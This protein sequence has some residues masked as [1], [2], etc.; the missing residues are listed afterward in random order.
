MQVRLSAPELSYSPGDVALV[1]P[2][3]LPDMVDSFFDLFPDLRPDRLF[4]LVP[5]SPN[6]LPPPLSLLPRPCTVRQAVTTYLD[7]QAVPS[8]YFFELLSHFSSDELE[9]EKCL[10]FNTG[11]GQQDLYEYCNRP[12]RHLLEVLHDFRHS[13]PNIPFDY[14]FDLVPAIK[15]RSFSIASSPARHGG[16][17]ELLVAVV[18]Y[19]SAID[20]TFRLLCSC[21]LHWYL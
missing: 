7:I 3:N 6:T 10:E 1:Q 11:E 17:V 15:P 19:R 4:H 14:L 12:R 2:S 8:R 20:I 13:T 18:K 5:S 9:K 16:V 21:S